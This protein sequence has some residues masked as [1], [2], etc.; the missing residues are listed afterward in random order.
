M[1]NP[2]GLGVI[3]FGFVNVG[4]HALPGEILDNG[5]GAVDASVVRDDYVIDAV[6]KMIANI[7]M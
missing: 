3:V 5:A 1:R 7:V 4:R 2:P 6:I